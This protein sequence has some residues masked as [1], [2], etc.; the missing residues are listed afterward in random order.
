MPSHC[1]TRLHTVALSIAAA[2]VVYLAPALTTQALAQE[3]QAGAG[4]FRAWCSRCHG[5]TGKGDGPI[6]KELETA[7]PDLTKL[8]AG[9]GGTFP[10]ERVQQSID[11][12]G[13]EA[14]HGTRQMPIWGDW[15]SFDVTAGGL[16]KTE[17][18]KTQ[19]EVAQRVRRITEYLRSIQD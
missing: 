3:A 17:K 7:L 15:F 18:A 1:F 12:R 14:G 13:M 8:S 10:A 2:A 9:N 19:A 5:Q 4:E 11:G 16:F 6:A